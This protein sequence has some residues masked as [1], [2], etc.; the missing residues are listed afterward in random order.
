[1][2]VDVDVRMQES[3]VYLFCVCLLFS[4]HS[5]IQ[6]MSKKVDIIKGMFVACRQ[7]EARYLIRWTVYI[8]VTSSV[9]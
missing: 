5:P 8:T 6:S 1:M 4:F 3:L 7:S 2:C 9:D